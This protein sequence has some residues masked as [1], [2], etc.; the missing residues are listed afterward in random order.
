MPEQIPQ[1]SRRAAESDLRSRY[2][3]LAR[4]YE[5]DLF[6]HAFR[7]CGGNSDWAKDLTQ[8]A[9]IAG[10]SQA[11]EGKL[12][13]SANVKGWFLRVVTTRFINEYRR[14]KRWQSDIPVEHV[15]S[16]SDLK[17]EDPF[18]AG[19]F[20]EPL[21]RALRQLP[22][23]QRLS[24][25]L[26]DVEQMSYAEAAEFLGIPVGTIRSRLARARMRLYE[27][28]MPYAKSRGII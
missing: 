1:T 4:R 27:L 7:L 24:V 16:T 21:E 14:K 23:E 12:D 20:D 3:L 2:S 15:D 17:P 8:D 18:V 13:F 9:L 22:D 11:L 19:T 5:S 25:L 28:L 6:R 10:Y 26:I